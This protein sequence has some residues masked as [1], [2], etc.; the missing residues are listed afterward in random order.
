MKIVP[1]VLMTIALLLGLQSQSYAQT[2]SPIPKAFHGK[3]AGMHTKSV[4]SV[5]DI[6]EICKVNYDYQESSWLLDIDSI[7]ATS[8]FYYESV[9]EST[10]HKY[11]TYSST[12]IKGIKK[13]EIYDFENLDDE[14][15]EHADVETYEHDGVEIS[16]HVVEIYPTETKYVPFEY[17][18]QNGK[19]YST[20]KNQDGKFVTHVFSRCPKK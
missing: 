7:S 6:Q 3:W 10:P 19:L 18:L 14:M 2:E 15:Y 9:E 20:F 13:V 11:T 17:K 1:S 5:K 4:P 12:H 8:T 16:H